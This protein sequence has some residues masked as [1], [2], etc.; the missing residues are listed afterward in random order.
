MMRPV[1]AMVAAIALLLT[2][3]VT[4]PAGAQTGAV[5]WVCTVDGVNVAFVSAP[6]A[7]LHGITQAD[8]KA[9]VVFETQFGEV[10]CHVESGP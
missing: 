1:K 4:G 5:R 3:A 10:N 2:L 9:G 8:S 6:E 7:A